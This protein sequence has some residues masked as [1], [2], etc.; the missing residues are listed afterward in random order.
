MRA[1]KV[2]ITFWLLM[3]SIGK[4]ISMTHSSIDSK[5]TIIFITTICMYDVNVRAIGFI[6]SNLFRCSLK[7]GSGWIKACNTKIKFK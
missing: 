6:N 4:I 7:Q 5:K 2:I 3:T 1:N